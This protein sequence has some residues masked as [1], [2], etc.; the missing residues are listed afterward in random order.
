MNANI[1]E[2]VLRYEERIQN[3]HT[4]QQI[5]EILNELYSP[6][7]ARDLGTHWQRLV[8]KAQAQAGTIIVK[9]ILG[10]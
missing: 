4:R 6:K 2:A 10:L 8:D 3:A 1:P 5:Y 7:A 9:S